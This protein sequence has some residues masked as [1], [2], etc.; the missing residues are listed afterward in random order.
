MNGVTKKKSNAL[1]R[2]FPTLPQRHPSYWSCQKVACG[3]DD[4][5]LVIGPGN[6]VLLPLLVSK[7]PVCSK[8]CAPFHP[9]SPTNYQRYEINVRA[10]MV[11][12][13]F[14]RKV[15]ASNFD[16][17]A[18]ILT[19]NLYFFSAFPGKCRESTSN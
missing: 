10:E 19:E 13:H 14:S 15:P 7:N 3:P 8:R 16:P 11:Q 12:C 17:E 4:L 1:L 18:P 6:T 5:N 9:L 2:R